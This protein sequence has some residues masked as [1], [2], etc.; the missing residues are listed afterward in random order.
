MGVGAL[1]ACPRGGGD[2]VPARGATVRVRS[3]TDTAP[4]SSVAAVSPYVFAATSR[5]LDRWDVT[6]GQR[7]WLTADHGLPGDRVMAIALDEGRRW[8]WV[9][10][11]GGLSRYDIEAGV[12][13]G[14]A[15]APTEAL[16]AIEADVR[17]VAPAGPGGVWVGGPAGLAYADPQADW[18]LVGLAQ[19][20][21]ALARDRAGTLWI[22]TA[23]HG[24]FVHRIDGTLAQLTEADHQAVRTVRFL[25]EAPGGAVIVVGDAADGAQRVAIVRDGEAASFRVAPD[26]RWLAAARRRDELVVLTPRRLY[27]LAAPRPGARRLRRDGARLVP[28][29]AGTDVAR[30]RSPFTIRAIDAPVPPGAIALAAADDRLVIGTR[31]QGTAVVTPGQRRVQWLRRGDLAGA[32]RR[33]SV[34]CAARADCYVATGGRT[35]WRFDGAAFSPIAGPPDATV[36]AVVAG[37]DGE[38][39]ALYRV[40]DEPRVRVARADGG[41]TPLDD[42]HIDTPGRRA[43]VSFAVRSPRGMVWIGLTYEDDTGQELAYGAAEVDLGLALV[44]YHHASRDAT[45]LA[46]GVLPIPITANDIA[47]LG[48]QEVWLASLE[49]AVRIAGRDVRVYGES[50]GL[51]SELVR[52]IA[53]TSGGIVFAATGVG[54][55]VFDGERWSAPR[56]LQRA[57]NAVAV[58]ADGRLWMA[59]PRGLAVYDGA[60]VRRL[61][62]RRGLLSDD[63][64][65]LAIDRFGRVWALAGAGVSIVTP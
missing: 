29:A 13:D 49:G 62:R 59:T 15:P 36:F 30:S 52:G 64:R 25:A 9:A 55:G 47:F 42:V 51:V 14:V 58:G 32:G 39:Y 41:F 26:V 37:G 40:G 48:D 20:V 2:A 23:G 56:P 46:R 28:L 1:S 57:V 43:G 21:T 60:R 34:A 50:D 61:D 4:V 44:A 27:A 18:R 53:V 31:D 45:D 17:A 22:G 8:L 5:G 7:L 54:V 38:V 33:I 16:S 3:F 10:T 6:T 63:V 35:A 19:P 12:F 65:D 11:D 24:L